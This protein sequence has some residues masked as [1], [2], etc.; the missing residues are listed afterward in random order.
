MIPQANELRR[1]VAKCTYC[2]QY[3]SASSFMLDDRTQ[4]VRDLDMYAEHM[5][6]A[7][8]GEKAGHLKPWLSPKTLDGLPLPKKALPERVADGADIVS[9][10]ESAV[11]KIQELDESSVGLI[12]APSSDAGETTALPKE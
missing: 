10:V 9:F 3:A 2:A 5:S 11:S 7:I 6:L 12:E 8:L 1:S 4:A